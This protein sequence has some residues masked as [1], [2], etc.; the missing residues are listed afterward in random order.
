MIGFRK[1][2]YLYFKTFAKYGQSSIDKPSIEKNVN[3]VF[4]WVSY[5]KGIDLL[6]DAFENVS[7]KVSKNISLSIYGRVGDNWH[8]WTKHIKTASLY[9]MQIRFL[10]I[11][12]FLK[13][14]NPIIT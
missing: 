7:K 4:G 10:K 8:E 13:F 5:Y 11:V 9:N 1:K 6:I 2:V 14:F 3:F 12:K